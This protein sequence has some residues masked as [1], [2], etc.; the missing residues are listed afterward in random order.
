MHK[1][2]SHTFM[3]GDPCDAYS[4]KLPIK[5]SMAVLP[6]SFVSLHNMWYRHHSRRAWGLDVCNST[7]KFI[8]KV[9]RTKNWNITKEKYFWQYQKYTDWSLDKPYE[10]LFKQEF[11]HKSDLNWNFKLK[12]ET[13][14]WNLKVKLDIDNEIKT[15]NWNLE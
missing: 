11:E 5:C 6:G 2:Y 3:E 9:F 7:I 10:L 4:R 12:S 1:F 8:S 14:T 13:C 15:W